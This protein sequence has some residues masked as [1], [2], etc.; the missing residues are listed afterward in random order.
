M[1]ALIICK[2]VRRVGNGF[3][4]EVRWPYGSEVI[5]CGEVVCR[6]WREVIELLTKAANEVEDK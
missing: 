3:I 4:V 2:E 1:S 5:G 6:T